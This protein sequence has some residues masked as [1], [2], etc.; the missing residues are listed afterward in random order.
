[1]SNVFPLFEQVTVEGPDDPRT[2]VTIAVTEI[3]AS[4][5]QLE[6]RI[7]ELSMHLDAIDIVIDALGEAGS[8]ERLLQ[9]TKNNREAL[10][11][12]SRELSENV[13][14]LLALRNNFVNEL[15]S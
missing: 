4:N 8:Q 1:M 6:R 7:K 13:R 15:S 14:M 10:M 3:M 11:H 9:L 5:A 2:R 12:A